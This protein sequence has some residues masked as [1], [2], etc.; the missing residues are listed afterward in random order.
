MKKGWELRRL[1]EICSISTGKWDANHA[2]E[3]GK[4]R[5]YTCAKDYVYSDTKRFSGESLILPGN[6]V[7]V[8]EVYYYNGEFDA[9]QRTYVMSNFDQA[10]K[11]VYYYLLYT[12]RSSNLNKQFGSATNFIKIGN[13]I[14]HSIPLPPLTEQQTIVSILDESFAAI[15]KAKENAEKNL[16]NAQEVLDSTLQHIFENPSTGWENIALGEVSKITDGTHFSPKNSFHGKYMYITAKNIKPYLI[17]LSNVTFI[18]EEDHKPIYA[19]CPVLKGDV[20]YIKDGATAGIATLNSLDDEFSLLSSVALI[21]PF[22][23]LLSTYLVHYMNSKIG[24]KNFLGYIDGAA[25]TRLTLVKIKNVIIPLPSIQEQES[26]VCVINNVF[27]ETKKLETIYKQ[28]LADL[29]ELKKSIL[30]KAFNG[31]LNTN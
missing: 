16:A 18:S 8:G 7:N 6:G 23:R 14:E 29:E 28:K 15:S 22:T 5:F 17:D 25:I 1:G 11:Y 3:N 13:F 19:R 12:W 24:R 21:K 10:V 31:E 30:E 9:Y 4:Y 27:E 2:V 20:L 26:I